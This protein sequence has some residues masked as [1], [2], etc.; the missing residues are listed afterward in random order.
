MF[1]FVSLVNLIICMLICKKSVTRSNCFVDKDTAWRPLY[2]INPVTK[3]LYLLGERMKEVS[4]CKEHDTKNFSSCL[5]TGHDATSC[6][7]ESSMA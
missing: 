6:F 7:K 3:V 2:T 4:N 1:N 5:T